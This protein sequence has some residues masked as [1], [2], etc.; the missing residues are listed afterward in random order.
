MTLAIFIVF[1]M[2][3]LVLLGRMLYGA[4][5]QRARSLERTNLER[6]LNNPGIRPELVF[7]LSLLN[8]S[9]HLAEPL[10]FPIAYDALAWSTTQLGLQRVIQDF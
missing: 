3:S 2:M 1:G 5:L 8:N 7:E 6:H 4:K 9:H 10:I